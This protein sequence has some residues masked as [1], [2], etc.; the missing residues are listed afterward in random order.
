MNCSQRIYTPLKSFYNKS[1]KAGEID[2][3]DL[4]GVESVGVTAGASTPDW[5][6]RK[7]VTHLEE[8]G[9][10]IRNNLSLK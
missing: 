2:E 10:R 3:N 9:E 1:R 8:L 5:L 4:I 6:I 7:V